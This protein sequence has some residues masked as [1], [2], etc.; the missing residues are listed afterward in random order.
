MYKVYIYILH[1]HI[2]AC[3]LY[4]YI[5]IFC[6]Q[7][8]SCGGERWAS[9]K[10]NDGILEVVKAMR[11]CNEQHANDRFCLYCHRDWEG[12]KQLTR[13]IS[14][15]MITPCLPAFLEGSGL[16]NVILTS[17]YE[18]AFYCYQSE[19]A[20]KSQHCGSLCVLV[21]YFQTLTADASCRVQHASIRFSVHVRASARCR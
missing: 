15:G 4:I 19:R 13:I 8:P 10:P 9:Q 6:L 5:C 17:V 21:A 3:I 2:C 14:T 7:W 16:S 18:A 11:A 1:I 12:M 20:R